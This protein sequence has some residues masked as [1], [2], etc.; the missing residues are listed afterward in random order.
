KE[1]KKVGTVKVR[2]GKG[3]K[4]HT[5]TKP[6][7]AIVSKQVKLVDLAKKA[8]KDEYERLAAERLKDLMALPLDE[9]VRLDV[10]NALLERAIAKNQTDYVQTLAAQV[11]KI[12]PSTDPAL[13]YLWDHAWAAYERGD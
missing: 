4:R 12:D 5:V 10:L 7:Y 2:V 8:K 6:K 3:K 9:D 13:Q 1:K 11:A